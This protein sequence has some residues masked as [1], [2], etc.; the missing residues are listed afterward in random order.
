MTASDWQ[1]MGIFRPQDYG[2][3]HPDKS[4]DDSTAFQA[5][6]DGLTASSYGG[7][8]LIPPGDYLV[9]DLVSTATAYDAGHRWGRNTRRI[10]GAGRG[11]T[12]LHA[13]TGAT[14]ILEVRGDE[15]GGSV[16]PSCDVMDLAFDANG[17]TLSHMLKLRTLCWSQF[18]RLWFDGNANVAK[19]IHTSG[20]LTCEFNG[21]WTFGMQEGLYMTAGGGAYDLTWAANA[22]VVRNHVAACPTWALHWLL[23]DG[24]QIDGHMDYEGCGTGWT[25]QPFT[26]STDTITVPSGH[27][28]TNGTPIVFRGIDGVVTGTTKGVTIGRVYYVRDV[29]S[30]SFKIATTVGGAAVDLTADATYANFGKA[31]TGGLYIENGR[32]AQTGLLWCEAN[33]ATDVKIAGSGDLEITNGLPLGGVVRNAGKLT[34]R[35]VTASTTV[36]NT[37]GT[38]NTENCPGIAVAAGNAANVWHA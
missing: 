20:M 6:L 26:A 30:T 36:D 34:A 12:K 33:L 37:G 19:G 23:G 9:G 1:A 25:S 14:G 18:H 28:L 8:M 21:L 16:L 35:R 22:I 11:A 10:Q 27:G 24:L 5:C 32:C 31:D 13:K 4:A 2:T 29:A 7:V 17:K 38:L 15:S 3:I